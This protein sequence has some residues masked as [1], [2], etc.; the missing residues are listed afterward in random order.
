MQKLKIAIV[1]YGQMGKRIEAL[2]NESGN[3]IVTNIFDAK[4]PITGGDYEVAIDFT[5]PLH[6]FDNVQK[7]AS[8]GKNIV[9]GTTGWYDD[10]DKMKKVIEDAGVGLVWGSNFSMGV[11]MYFRIVRAAARLVEKTDGYDTFAHEIHHV[12]KK[13]SPSG[14]AESIG[15]ILMEELSGKS[16]LETGRID[17]PIGSDKLHFSSSR[18]GDIFG[19]HTVYFDSLADTIEIQHNAKGRDGFALG[20]LHAA[21]WI[22]DRK[23]FHSFD[24]LMDD[25]FG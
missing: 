8:Y 18:G 14:T 15:K 20:S 1:G 6:A 21:Q 11:Q 9:L 5:S 23:G 17:E 2:A 10:E 7:L 24:E 19:R 22:A 3:F 4:N 25:V 16:K 12:R 13:D